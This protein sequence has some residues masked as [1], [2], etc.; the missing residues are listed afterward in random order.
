MYFTGA[1][2]FRCCLAISLDK[3][4]LLSRKSTC[5]KSIGRRNT[6]MMKTT[7][8]TYEKINALAFRKP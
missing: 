2:E 4:R 7:S 5:V 8:N 6:H 3:P 1:K